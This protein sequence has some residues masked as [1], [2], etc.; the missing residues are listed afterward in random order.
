[1]SGGLT[2][3]SVNFREADHGIFF[4]VYSGL[5]DGLEYAGEDY[6]VAE[7]AGKLWQ[8]RRALSR[9]LE[10]RGA[11]MGLG[12]TLDIRR[13]DFHTN[14]L[15]VWNAINHRIS[16]ELDDSPFNVVITGPYL[17]IPTGQSWTAAFRYFGHSMSDPDPDW[18]RR[19]MVIQLQTV[20][21]PP[22]WVVVGP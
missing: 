12:A 1:M 18:A 20:Q 22:D 13:G 4:D 6:D 19:A 11:V 10:L 9:T 8:P 21:S 5:Y 3:N 15:A 2:V 14:M 16:S 17:G 7:A